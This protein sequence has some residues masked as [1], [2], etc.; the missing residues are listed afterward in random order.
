MTYIAKLDAMTKDFF[1]LEPN[2]EIR[3]L[4]STLVDNFKVTQSS[5]RSDFMQCVD[6]QSQGRPFLCVVMFD[7]V[8]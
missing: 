3:C 7:L 6:M 1:F 4:Y 2:S 8:K 5:R